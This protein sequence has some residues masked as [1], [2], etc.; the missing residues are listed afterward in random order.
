MPWLLGNNPSPLLPPSL[1]ALSKSPQGLFQGVTV[2]SSPLADLYHS[3]ELETSPNPPRQHG[4]GRPVI[5]VLRQ[6]SSKL[7]PH[8]SPLPQAQALKS[9]PLQC[10]TQCLTNFS[11]FS[12]V[13]IVIFLEDSRQTSECPDHPRQVNCQLSGQAEHE[14][15][16]YATALHVVSGS[17]TPPPQN[18]SDEQLCHSTPGSPRSFPSL[19]PDLQPPCRCYSGG[20]NGERKACMLLF[21]NILNVGLLS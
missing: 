13:W 21:T 5:S 4:G 6:A 9:P 17:L 1:I 3:F 16:A 14:D 19:V 20:M 11:C 10:A 12:P 18:T 8:F 2:F 7:I 15:A